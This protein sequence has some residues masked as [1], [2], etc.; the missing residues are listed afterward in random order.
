MIFWHLL[1]WRAAMAQVNMCNLILEYK[2]DVF[3]PR[4]ARHFSYGLKPLKVTK[5]KQS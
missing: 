3:T 4:L 2:T 1:H 5:N